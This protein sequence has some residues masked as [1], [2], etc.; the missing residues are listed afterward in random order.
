MQL[1]HLTHFSAKCEV[2]SI[3]MVKN[4]TIEV[5]VGDK[6]E[7]YTLIVSLIVSLEEHKRILNGGK[8]VIKFSKLN[9][10]KCSKNMI[11]HYYV[12]LLL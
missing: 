11:W 2:L 6:E 10:K 4:T 8:L 12:V 1:M 7:L 9:L 3:K 5:L